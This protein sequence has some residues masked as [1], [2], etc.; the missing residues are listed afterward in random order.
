MVAILCLA[1]PF[2]ECL[3]HMELNS[4]KSALYKERGRVFDSSFSGRVVTVSAIPLG[5]DVS[6]MSI[7]ALVQNHFID[8]TSVCPVG[9]FTPIYITSVS[10]LLQLLKCLSIGLFNCILHFVE[11]TFI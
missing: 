9:C 8:S 1:V 3:F 2:T 6:A 4:R 5:T 11:V 10:P 7:S